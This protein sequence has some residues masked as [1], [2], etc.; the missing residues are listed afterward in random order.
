MFKELIEKLNQKYINKSDNDSPEAKYN[1]R[2]NKEENLLDKGKEID[3]SNPK[4]ER[5]YFDGDLGQRATG[6]MVNAKTSG[7]TGLFTKRQ[8]N[9]AGE[10]IEQKDVDTAHIDS[11][12]IQRIRY[13]PKTGDLYIT[14]KNG[15]GTQYLFPN[16]PEDVVRRFLNASSKGRYYNRE[17]KK[18]SIARRSK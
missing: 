14:F 8:M 9:E 4:S 5:Y 11:T 18:Y 3:F 13:N 16:V 10:P 1:K 17:V 15:K 2:L 7:W 12:A 6:N